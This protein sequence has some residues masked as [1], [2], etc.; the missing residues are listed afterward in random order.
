M[1][2]LKLF[3]KNVAL[4]QYDM[5]R[6]LNI[7]LSFYEKIERGHIQPSRAF[8][9]KMKLIFPDISIDEIFFSGMAVEEV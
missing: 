3:R 5:A 9:Q 8:M 2:K 6:R 7:S 4:S 1:K